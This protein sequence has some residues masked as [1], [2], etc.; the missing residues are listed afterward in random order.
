MLDLPGFAAGLA[1][2]DPEIVLVPFNQVPAWMFHLEQEN[3]RWRL[4]YADEKDAVYL[5]RGFAPQVAALPPSRPGED[6]PVFSEE[7][8]DRIL[9]EAR[10]HRGFAPLR[11]LTGPHHHPMAEAQRMTFHLLRDEPEAA[12]GFGLLG[13][14]GGTVEVPSLWHNLAVAFEQLGDTERAAR[15]RSIPTSPP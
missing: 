15:C 1:R 5:R 12:L 9:E 11:I 14:R 4:V 13:L 10:G 7:E 3:A 8:V 2:W 6:Y